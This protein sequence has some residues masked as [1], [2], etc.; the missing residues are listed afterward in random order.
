MERTKPG[1]E[2]YHRGDFV[3]MFL[4]ELEVLFGSVGTLIRVMLGSK[5]GN[6]VERDGKYSRNLKQSTPL[7][8][9]PPCDGAHV[10]NTTYYTL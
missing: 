6:D 4:V 1:A 10:P 7:W 3:P 8:G 2:H 5:F 9:G